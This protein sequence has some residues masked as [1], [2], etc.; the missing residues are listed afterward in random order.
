[1]C[2]TWCEGPTRERDHA[3]STD[4]HVLGSPSAKGVFQVIE[5]GRKGRVYGGMRTD[6]A[7]AMLRSYDGNAKAAWADGHW[8]ENREA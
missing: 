6:V 4:L 8:L 3:S 1:M 2:F 7:P 5:G